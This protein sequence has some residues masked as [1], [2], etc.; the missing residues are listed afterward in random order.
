MKLAESLN[1]R[2]DIQ[3]RIEQ[4]KQRLF[5][6]ARV[7]EGEEPP[8]D[9]VQLLTELE[10][11]SSELEMLIR[12]INKANSLTS[13]QEEGTLSDALAKRDILLMK[14]TVYSSLAEVASA[15]QDRYSR[16]EIKYVSTV[17]ISEMRRTVDELSQQYRLL[18]STIQAANW[19]TDLLD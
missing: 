7:Q 9:P 16:S 12:R 3:K 17:N 5:T 13:F 6:S 11:L 19:N 10:R 14:R 8:E 18:D 4:L 15:R 2:A 1:L